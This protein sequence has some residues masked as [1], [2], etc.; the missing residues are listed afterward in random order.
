MNFDFG[1][2][3]I[4]AVCINDSNTNPHCLKEKKEMLECIMLNLRISAKGRYGT[5]SLFIYSEIQYIEKNC[6]RHWI[7]LENAPYHNYI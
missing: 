2:N 3:K 1:I 4:V 5:K 6:S 7:L